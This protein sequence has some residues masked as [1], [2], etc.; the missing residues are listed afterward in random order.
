MNIL[1]EW[2]G[3]RRTFFLVCLLAAVMSSASFGQQEY[4]H[5][6]FPILFSEHKVASTF[7]IDV[8][9]WWMPDPVKNDVRIAWDYTYWAGLKWV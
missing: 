2:C 8:A 1:I 4:P 5:R 9:P 3:G 7:G 6:R